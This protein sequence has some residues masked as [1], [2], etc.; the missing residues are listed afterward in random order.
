MGRE[1]ICLEVSLSQSLENTS[2]RK[3]L[4]MLG[5]LEAANIKSAT[6]LLCSVLRGEVAKAPSMCSSPDISV[7]DDSF[8]SLRKLE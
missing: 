2:F 4:N 3:K 7:F 6:S 5:K 1:A 8:E